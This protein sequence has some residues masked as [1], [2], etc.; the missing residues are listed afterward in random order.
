MSSSIRTHPQ[1]VN[2]RRPGEIDFYLWADTHDCP[3]EVKYQPE[4]RAEDT[5]MLRRVIA[6]RGL[7]GGIL[8][9][10]DQWG[11]AGGI[12]SVP[13]WAFMLLA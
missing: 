11:A 8:V 12:C 7:P 6:D 5:A 3:I 9:N 13:L 4:I 2:V 10:I 1:S